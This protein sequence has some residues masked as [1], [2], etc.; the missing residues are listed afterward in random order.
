MGLGLLV[1]YGTLALEAAGTGLHVHEGARVALIV[2]FVWLAVLAVGVNIPRYGSFV[3]F[4]LADVGA[5]L[6]SWVMLV[7]YSRGLEI[8]GFAMLVVGA[9]RDRHL[10]LRAPGRGVVPES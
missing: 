6:V 9:L 8:L 3:P 7:E 4:I 5:L 2:A 10:R 1:C